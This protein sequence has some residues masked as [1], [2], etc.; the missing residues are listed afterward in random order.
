MNREERNTKI[1][2]LEAEIAE[3]KKQYFCSFCGKSSHDSLCLIAGPGVFICD[4]CVDIC[5]GVVNERRSKIAV[6]TSENAGAAEATKSPSAP[7]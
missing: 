5:A 7:K 1:S 2:E 3:L 6:G 4:E